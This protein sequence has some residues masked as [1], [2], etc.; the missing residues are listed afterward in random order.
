MV[1]A[2]TDVTTIDADGYNLSFFSNGTVGSFAVN[3]GATVLQLVAPVQQPS[4]TAGQPPLVSVVLSPQYGN[5]AVGTSQLVLL[6]DST[7]AQLLRATFV[8][9]VG[10]ITASVQIAKGTPS[11]KFV[12]FTVASVAPAAVWDDAVAVLRFVALPLRFEPLLG[13]ATLAGIGYDSDVAVVLLPGVLNVSVEGLPRTNSAFFARIGSGKTNPDGANCSL[14]ASAFG[15]SGFANVSVTLWAGPR[16]ALPA[17]VQLGE[18]ALGLPSPQLGGGGKLS[19]QTAL[20]ASLGYFLIDIPPN[21]FNKT[22]EYAHAAGFGYIVL[23][24]SWIA[25]L[26]GQ[27]AMYGHYNVSESWAG[28]GDGAGGPVAGLRAAVKYANTRGVK[29][30][31]HTLSGNIAMTDSYVTPVPDPRLAVLPGHWTL[32]TSMDVNATAARLGGNTTCLAAVPL[33]ERCTATSCAPCPGATHDI[34]IGDELL[35]YT[36]LNSSTN[37]LSGLVR[38]LHGT[39]PQPHGA[40]SRVHV[41]AAGSGPTYLPTGTL[42]DE[43]GTNIARAVDNVGAD[44]V[45][46]DGLG[47]MFPIVSGGATERFACSRMQLAFWRSCQRQVLAQ[48]DTEGEWGLESGHLWREC[49][50]H[51]SMFTHVSSVSCFVYRMPTSSSSSTSDTVL[52]M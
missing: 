42:I 52:A 27:E 15:D 49:D 18:R 48:A 19:P 17:A 7:E 25:T 1:V 24:D 51:A 12:R 14:S 6:T 13:C 35:S 3:T 21:Q 5:A 29:I 37:M 44:T 47:Q 31:L 50:A 38:G 16:D 10:N 46:F 30:G 36:T 4:E 26:P 22:V 39:R 33:S 43:I 8:T 20:E 32:A 2:T 11:S 41:M 9:P 45:Y 28:W 23:L 40:G 34:R